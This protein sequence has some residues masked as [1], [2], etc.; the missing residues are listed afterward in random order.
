MPS[1][2]DAAI[3]MRF[4]ASRGQHASLYAHGNRTRQQSC[5]QFHCGADP[6]HDP[7]TAGTV[8]DPSAGQ[9][10][11]HII[12]DTFCLLQNTRFRASAISQKCISCETSFRFQ[13]FKLWKRSFRARPPFQIPSVQ[14]LKTKLSCKTSFSD[15]KCSSF[16]TKL[17]C[18]T[19]FSD[20][21]CSSFENEAF[22]QDLLFKF[23]VL[24]LWKRSFRARPPSNSKWSSFENEAFNLFQLWKRSFRA[25]PP[26]NSHCSSFEN[27][28]FVRDILQFLKVEDVTT[29]RLRARLPSIY[30]SWRCA[31]EAF[32]RDLLHFFK[33]W[34]CETK[35]SCETSFKFQLFKLW[36]EAFVQDLLFKFQVLKLWKR[37]HSNFQT[38]R[39]SDIQTLRV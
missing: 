25:R 11:P 22:V 20:S 31:N 35:L 8:R 2:L 19:S 13:V 28:A 37:R 33:G 38:F 24:K 36:N 5:R 14:A 6:R 21:K 12:R 7:G 17:S 4:A 15:S 9:A 27:E 16:E 10:S 34:R 3:T 18:K 32:V 39:L 26:S 1:N 29:K 23:L 30:E